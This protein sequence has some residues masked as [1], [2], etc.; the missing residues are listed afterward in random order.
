MNNHK[1]LEWAMIA[2]AA[3]LSFS[4][5]TFAQEAVHNKETVLCQ[6][7]TGCEPAPIAASHAAPRPLIKI[8]TMQA[9]AMMGENGD[10]V[11]ALTTE[12]GLTIIGKVLGPQGEDISGALLAT[13]PI[14]N[15]NTNHLSSSMVN[16]PARLPKPQ[17]H[18][19]VQGR[20]AGT[21]LGAP[22]PANE[23]TPSATRQAPEE[24]ARRSNEPFTSPQQTVSNSLES[25]R[26]TS[27][28][29][30]PAAAAITAVDVPSPETQADLNQ[31]LDEA[32][33]QRLWFSA[34]KPQ[35]DAPVVYM[36]AD[37]D[38]PY[39][40]S[41]IDAWRTQIL[42]GHIDLRIIPAP[43]TGPPALRTTLSILH[44]KDVAGTFMNHMTSKSRGTP[45]VTQMDARTADR[46]VVQSVGDNVAWMRRNG[47]GSVP[48]FLYKDAKG[49]TF[50]LANLPTNILQ[51]AK[52][53]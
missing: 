3:L 47:I 32:T 17:Q 34:A 28:G 5:P 49:A 14:Q 11:L 8:G 26:V 15:P 31:L 2:A 30:T 1:K 46:D 52:S 38:C 50:S 33:N 37:P 40:Q 29:I 45:A 16:A 43:I 12:D 41:A 4:A 22:V 10:P 44:S 42:S 39:C 53:F 20:E 35:P 27:T 18:T 23:Q 21:A 7:Q 13:V 36:V 19:F 51:I 25:H 6:G 48:F 9:W 24:R